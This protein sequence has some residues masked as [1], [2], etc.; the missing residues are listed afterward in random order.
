MFKIEG[1]KIYLTRGDTLTA[2]V[3]IKM[4]GEDY[5]PVDG[6]VVRFAMKT[7][8]IK[9][10]GSN[11]YE[12]NPLIEKIIPNDTMVLTLNP[13]DTENLSFGEYVY[14]I[15]I[16]FSN[17]SVDTFIADARLVLTREVC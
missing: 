10:D 8:R 1:T 13:G 11:F 12:E 9:P 16:T 4:D 15:Q 3:S 7:N 17:G 6:D 5:Q 14:D 2:N